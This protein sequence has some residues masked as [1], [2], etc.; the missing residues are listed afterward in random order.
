MKNVILIEFECLF[1]CNLFSQASLSTIEFSF[2]P[3]PINLDG[4]YAAQMF[5]YVN[6][7]LCCSCSLVGKGI[8]LNRFL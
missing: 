5:Y 3:S 1:F 2:Q 8:P 4:W 7:R 6:E